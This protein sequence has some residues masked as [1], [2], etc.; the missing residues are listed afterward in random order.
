MNDQL[1]S[2]PDLLKSLVGILMRFPQ[3]LIAMSADI[4]AMF[5]HVAVPEEDQSVAFCLEKNTG[6][7]GERVPIH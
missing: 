6:G 7:Q 5:N 1:L 4:E 2:G 3:E